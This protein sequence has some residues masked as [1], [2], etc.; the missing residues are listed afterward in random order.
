MGVS[1]LYDSAKDVLK[2]NNLSIKDNINIIMR[3]GGM[4]HLSDKDFANV[5]SNVS[6]ES[7]MLTGDDINNLA[8]ARDKAKAK[9]TPKEMGG[10]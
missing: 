6:T 10:D 2:W 5:K 3:I 1:F 9:S 8:L 7:V 4:L